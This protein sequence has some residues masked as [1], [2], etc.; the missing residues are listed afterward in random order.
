[1]DLPAFIDRIGDEKAAQLFKEKER[2][3]KSW[4][5]RERRPKPKKAPRI[6][7][8]SNGVLDYESI[9]SYALKSSKS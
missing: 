1:M 7:K 5:L 2:I 4:R 6:I 9:F 3:V 8:A